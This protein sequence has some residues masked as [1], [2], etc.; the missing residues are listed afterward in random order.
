MWQLL[1]NTFYVGEAKMRE[2][3]NKVGTEEIELGRGALQIECA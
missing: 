1:Y 2:R 3:F